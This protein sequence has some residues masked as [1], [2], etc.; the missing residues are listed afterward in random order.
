MGA[1]IAAVLGE[2]AGY[3]HLLDPNRKW[4]NNRRSVTAYLHGL[5]RLDITSTG[6]L[7][8]MPGLYS[9]VWFSA[10]LQRVGL[11]IYFSLITSSTNG[12]DGSMM[13][14]LQSLTQWEDAFNHPTGGILG[15]LNA[16]QVSL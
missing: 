15:L 14:G 2:K 7:F 8:S 3:A 9:C 11:T 16:I 4:Y 10:S 6:S 12:Y 13:N 5:L 1:G